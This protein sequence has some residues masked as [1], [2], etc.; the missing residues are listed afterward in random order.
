MN[1][2]FTLKIHREI[3]LPSWVI[4]DTQTW[5]RDEPTLIRITITFFHTAVIRQTPDVSFTVPSGLKTRRDVVNEEGSD[6][7]LA[8]QCAQF[9]SPRKH[10]NFR[11]FWIYTRTSK[12]LT[13]SLH[14]TLTLSHKQ[15]WSNTSRRCTSPKQWPCFTFV[16]NKQLWYTY[17]LSGEVKHPLCAEDGAR[18]CMLHKTCWRDH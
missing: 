16:R 11:L 17:G 8:A 18:L 1:D 7:T 5:K 13:W 6:L 12:L 10:T 15:Q 9:Y 2:T 4:F 3:Q 14:T